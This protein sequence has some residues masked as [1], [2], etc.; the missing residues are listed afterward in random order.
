MTTTTSLPTDPTS[1]RTGT[2]RDT[3]SHPPYP[4][5]ERQAEFIALAN[6]LA[7]VAA[8]NASRH[9]AENTFPFDTFKALRESGFLALTVPEE[10]GGRGASALEVMLAQERL[11]RGDGGV[12][13]GSTMSLINIAG[14]A[15]NRTWPD[16][17]WE[18]FCRDVVEHGA[19]INNIASEPDLGSPSRG[20]MYATTAQWTRDG[21]IISG[22]KA[23]A[24]LSPALDYAVV[25]LT[26]IDE[27]GERA[28]GNILVPMKLPGITVKE[29]W[30][31]LGMRSSGSH[32]VVF[33]N[34]LVPL[35]NLLPAP[36][37]APGGAT[38]PWSLV[39]SAVYLG[40]ATAARDFAVDFAQ[41]RV[42]SG[43]GKPIAELQTIQHRIAQIELLLLQSRS[44]LYGTVETWDRFPDQRKAISWQFAAAKYTVTNNAIAITDQALRVVGSVGLQKKH[45][46]E[47]YFRDVRAGLGNPPMDDIALTLIGKNALGVS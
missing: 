5:T 17:L 30:D 21:W 18:R 39:T 24:T 14:Q 4:T 25:M 41:H 8:A 38:S 29:T 31:N 12:A 37:G 43:L 36:Q 33:E 2:A 20:G 44:V 10:L 46:L 3:T 16:E 15:A 42:P 6:D 19:L 9:D 1:D 34:V 32:D 26:T 13:F 11:A 7:T 40:I 27:Q 23:W 35:E 47:R 28:R 45:P 22:H